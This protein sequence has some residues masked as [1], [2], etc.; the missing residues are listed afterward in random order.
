VRTAA[1][2]LAATP[3]S[4]HASAL[5]RMGLDQPRGLSER[6]QRRLLV[7]ALDASA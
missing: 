1:A 5:R 2:S 3:A 6:L 4:R 7:L